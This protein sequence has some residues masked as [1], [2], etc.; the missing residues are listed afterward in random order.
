MS[1]VRE[2]CLGLEGGDFEFEWLRDGAQLAGS[3]VGDAAD[4]NGGGSD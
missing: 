1:T 2:G 3:G 4:D